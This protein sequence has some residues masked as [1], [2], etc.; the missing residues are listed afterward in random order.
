MKP[1]RQAS[2]LVVGR[3]KT[4]FAKVLLGK[5]RE[6]GAV[7]RPPRTAFGCKSYGHSFLLR[8]LRKNSLFIS[9]SE[10][11]RPTDD[12]LLL[13]VLTPQ[14]REKRRREDDMQMNLGP[15]GLRER[16]FAQHLGDISRINNV[17]LVFGGDQ[18]IL[19]L[20]RRQS[21]LHDRDPGS[22]FPA[23]LSETAIAEWI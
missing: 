19:L 15:P 9:S 23:F 20:S 8:R 22:T 4:F 14:R 1:R 12:P 18:E 13:L 3:E 2:S 17:I 21:E 11:H 10:D 5:E 6:R 7:V 16:E